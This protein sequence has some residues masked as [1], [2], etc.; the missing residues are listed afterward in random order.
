MVRTATTVL[1]AAMIG[2]G[3]TGEIITRTVEYTH[4][5]Q[6]LRGFLAYDDAMEGERPGVLVVHEWWG[7][8]DYPKA[9]ARQLAD[10]GYV[11]FAVDMYGDGRVASTPAEAGGLAGRF[12]GNVEL[13]R[14]RAAAGLEVLKEHEAVD[15]DRLA[16]IGFCFGGTVCLQ[17]A[18]SGADVDAV[19]SFHGG[20]TPPAAKDDENIDA[21][22]LILHG[23][24]DTHVPDDQ[25]RAFKRALD[26]ADVDWTFIEYSDAEHAFSNPEAEDSELDGVDYDERAAEQSWRHMLM[27]L[28]D[29]FDED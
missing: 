11:A 5:G 9:R 13:T 22:F 15:D 28:E 21:E 1:A 8:N 3:A 24:A 4:D 25:V 12:R 6:T 19:V 23:A 10:A 27:F 26:R 7:L 20:L 14:A 2:G 29:A 18:Y 16:A 17:L